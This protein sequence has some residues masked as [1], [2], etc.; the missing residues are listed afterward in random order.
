MYKIEPHVDNEKGG[1]TKTA[2]FCPS[3]FLGDFSD[4]SGVIG[5]LVVPGDV[6]GFIAFCLE[7]PSNNVSML[8]YAKN[9]LSQL[10]DKDASE[11]TMI[12]VT[13]DGG[14]CDTVM[15]LRWCSSIPTVPSNQSEGRNVS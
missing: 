5:P 2:T 3:H 15:P 9:G 1:T 13:V 7:P 4:R 14:A 11:W 12:E 10:S 6:P 8:S